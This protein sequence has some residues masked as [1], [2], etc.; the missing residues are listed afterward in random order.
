M[1]TITKPQL[2]GKIDD[3]KD[4]V[5]LKCSMQIVFR[6]FNSKWEENTCPNKEL[7]IRV[8]MKSVSKV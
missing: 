7:G 2:W 8:Y 6:D 4:N 1:I 3:A 5:K